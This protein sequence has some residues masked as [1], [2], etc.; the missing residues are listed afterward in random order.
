MKKTYP[1][2][3]FLVLLSVCFCCVFSTVAFSK[4]G[5]T[6]ALQD[7]VDNGSVKVVIIGSSTAEGYGVTEAESWVG[8]Y[9]S[10]LK[11]INPAHEVV[12]LGIGGRT[13]YNLL[14][15]GM[16]TPVDDKPE[17]ERNITKA[18]SLNPDA[19]IINLP[20]NDT[21]DGYSKDAQM[22]NF[23]IMYHA[24]QAQGV[25]VWIT[26]TQP[27][28]K[29]L[30]SDRLAIQLAVRD[31]IK[32][33][34]GTFALDFWTG[35][36]TSDNKIKPAYALGDGI[37]LNGAGHKVLFEEVVKQQVLEKTVAKKYPSFVSVKSGTYTDKTTWS[38]NAVPNAQSKVIIKAGHTVSLN[39]DV[40][41]A[42]LTIEKTG[43][44]DLKTY[45]FSATCGLDIQGTLEAAQAI[46]SLSGDEDMTLNGIAVIKTLKINKNQGT[47]RL[48]QDMAVSSDLTLIKGDIAL[49]GHLLTLESTAAI[50][51]GSASSYI[52]TTGPGDLVFKISSSIVNKAL[53]FPVGDASNYTPFTFVLKSGSVSNGK[54]SMRV[55]DS[56]PSQAGAANPILSRYWDL[57]QEGLSNYLYD[58]KYQYTD[59]DVEVSS[60]KGEG[61]LKVIK[62]SDKDGWLIGGE[63][64]T[65][66]NTLSA[67]G[68]SSFSIF[69]GGNNIEGAGPLPVTLLSFQVEASEEGHALL[70]WKTASEINNDYF[71]VERSGDAEQWTAIAQ[72]KGGGTSYNLLSY[73]FVDTSP[74]MGHNYYRLKQVDFDGQ[75]EYSPVVHFYSDLATSFDLKLAPNPAYAK[76]GLSVQLTTPTQEG[77]A[78]MIVTDILGRTHILREISLEH[79]KTDLMVQEDLSPGLYLVTVRQGY[80]VIQ[81]KLLLY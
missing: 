12:N 41:I 73:R 22:A 24:A 37:H 70:Q 10:Y 79:E 53:V 72:V 52:Q 1:V 59:S 6:A 17:P 71:A 16:S 58:V 2:V 14:P 32:Q 42:A 38:T 74:A 61:D 51:G 4:Q 43:K 55:V 21:W 67:T 50:T 5:E 81:K 44:L 27:R 23:K 56:E 57:R 18:L 65:S 31:A 25:P 7:C 35:I 29:G 9:A 13:T 75:F 8:R 34:Y 45:Q 19:I 62:Y 63:V 28:E 49:S 54:L 80:R 3:T 66:T 30:T 46:L 40:A 77:K 76:E 36:A 47:V 11:S 48:G 26:T 20:S 68:I 15:T 64:N 60:G 39:A 69:S 78:T 33:T